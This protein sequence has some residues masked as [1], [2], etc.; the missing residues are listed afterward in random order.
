MAI[1]DLIA[2]V[3]R[4]NPYATDE[5]IA[6]VLER[7][8]MKPGKSE[9]E[10][11]RDAAIMSAASGA[12][13]MGLEAATRP[14]ATQANPKPS[15]YGYAVPTA[16]AGYNAYDIAKN[17]KLTKEQQAQNII[18]ETGIAGAN[19]ATGGLAG[20]A[21]YL[22][23]KTGK[24]REIEREST[25]YMF[26]DPT[27][28]EFW[29]DP[30]NL[31]AIKNM[32]IVGDLPIADM[33]PFVPGLGQVGM[34]AKLLSMSGALGGLGTKEKQMQRAGELIKKGVTGYGDFY[35]LTKIDRDLLKEKFKDQLTGARGIRKD[36][37][38]GF[39]GT[40]PASNQWVNNAFATSGQVKDLRPEDVWGSQGA[41]STFGNEWLGKY[42]EDQRRKISQALLDAAL[43][44]LDHGDVIISDRDKALAV[45]DEVLGEPG[46][47]P[48]FGQPTEEEQ[49]EAED[50]AESNQVPATDTQNTK[51]AGVLAY[52][53]SRDY[54]AWQN[55]GNNQN[56]GASA[57]QAAVSAAM[58]QLNK[59]RENAFLGDSKKKEPI[60]I[61]WNYKKPESETPF[62][63]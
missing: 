41:F 36:L 13:Q 9:T 4:R 31:P 53:P 56:P 62:L 21:R 16:L 18:K 2:E 19:Y 15:G 14:A 20:L 27:K 30:K 35:G 48:T 44:K 61:D 1:P 10:Q 32:P 45:R 23:N 28:E 47:A 12:A 5:M 49:R 24:G 42:N 54:S 17:D 11:I 39:V 3:K 7:M 57:G 37:D 26:Q 33:L 50:K 58:D 43:F 8:G 59:P 22:A 51:G 29:K 25:E 34:A 60:K 63:K 38:A 46:G 6:A 40:D 52:A 55:K